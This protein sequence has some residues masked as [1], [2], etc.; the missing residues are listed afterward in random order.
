M[1]IKEI[2]ITKLP[3]LYDTPL[4]DIKNLQL[5]EDKYKKEQEK[6]RRKHQ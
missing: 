3:E 6:W 2:T 1:V 5:K 4:I